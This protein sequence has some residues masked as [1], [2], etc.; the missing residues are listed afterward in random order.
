MFAASICRT[1]T[2]DADVSFSTEGDFVG[3]AFRVQSEDEYELFFFRKGA[4]G[5]NQALQYTPG[6]LGANAWQIYNVPTYAGA[7]ELPPAD[8][9]LHV[10]VVV[11]GLEAKLFLNNAAEPSLVIPDLKQGYST[12]SIGFL[13]AVGRRLHLQCHLHTR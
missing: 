2:I 4:S 8:Q 5:S 9:W 6:F 12:G 7:G 3:I 10:K 13:G 11:T 1:A